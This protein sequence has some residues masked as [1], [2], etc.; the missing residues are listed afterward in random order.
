[1]SSPQKITNYFKRPRF[2]VTAPTLDHGSNSLVEDPAPASQSSPLTELS[3]LL[4]SDFTAPDTPDGPSSQLK[5]SLLFSA[6]EPADNDPAPQSSFQS[7]GSGIS[8]KSS[9]RVIKKGKEV[10]IGSDG[11]ESDSNASL[12]SADELLKD[13]RT[14]STPKPDSDMDDDSI[15]AEFLRPRKESKPRNAPKGYKNS[16]E[17]LVMQAVSDNDTETVIKKL[18]ASQAAS[19]NASGPD[20]TDIF[21]ESTLAAAFGDGTEGGA[22]IH[23]LIDAMRR[24][25]ALELTKSWSFFDLQTPLPLPPDFPR[26]CVCPGTYMAVLREPD[27]RE[28]AFYSGIVDYALSRDLLPDELL[29]WIFY[30]IPSEPRDNLRHAYCRAIKRTTAERLKRLIGPEDI[31][32]LF[33]HLSARPEALALNDPIILEVH[34]ES[35]DTSESQPPHHIALLSVLGIFCEA[36]RRFADDTRNQILNILLRLALDTSLTRNTILC[37]ELERTIT[38]VLD[39]VPDDVADDLANNICNNA[40]TTLKDPESQSHLLEHI[41]PLNDWIATLRRRLAYIFLKRNPSPDIGFQE[42]KT[43]IHELINILKE[44]RFDVK[45]YKRKGQPDY[46]YGELQAIAGFLNIIIDSAWSE[47]KFFDASA[48]ERFN[49][50]VDTLA[51]RVKKIFSAIEDSGANFLSRTLAKEALESLHYR[52]VYSVRTK[53]RPK[54]SFF[55]AHPEPKTQNILNFAQKKKVVLLSDKPGS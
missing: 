17:S 1:M 28:R 20:S 19:E 43:E 23:R 54:K 41:V 10:V 36:A 53:P 55:S 30:S 42:R 46:N 24:T 12:L 3:Q 49:S 18:R 52:I 25:E 29:K 15:L 6:E 33:W 21:G 45:R 31:D 34:P 2:A 44:S 7:A 47:T 32:L 35:R 37:S 50:E 38:A 39:A 27:S 14:P 26:D 5:R 9:Q 13:I 4:P 22:P 51:E 48:E 16:M 8:L 40:Y 11:D